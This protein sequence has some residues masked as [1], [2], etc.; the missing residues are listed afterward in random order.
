MIQVLAVPLRRSEGGPSSTPS[1]EGDLLHPLPFCIWASAHTGPVRFTMR[2]IRHPE[3][4]CT[5]SAG[6]VQQSHGGLDLQFF[7]KQI[8][9]I[10]QQK[11]SKDI[12]EFQWE[13]KW[14]ALWAL[15][16]CFWTVECYNMLQCD[17]LICKLG[18]SVKHRRSPN[19]QMTMFQGFIC[20]W[21]ICNPV[22]L[23]SYI[24]G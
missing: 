10:S 24:V 9:H 4:L 1:S 20:G 11:S 12:P 13:E 5:W 15:S 14:V 6:L 19:S 7:E 2:T 18:L 16:A 23:F 21:V 8:I 3:K 22:C 17:S